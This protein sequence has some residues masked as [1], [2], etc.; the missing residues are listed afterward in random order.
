M[1]LMNKPPC[2]ECGGSC[3]KY[4]AVEIDKPTNKTDYDN[5]RWYLLHKNVGVFIDHDK[6]WFIEFRTSCE[7]QT[8]DGRCG[9]YENRPKICREHGNYE[10]ECEFYDNPYMEYF[11][12]E[13]EFLSYLVEKNKDWKFKKL[14]D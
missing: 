4:V 8:E 11:S 1:E 10:G 3:C 2:E 9:I 12:T 5:I 13:D 7:K 6:N 14:R